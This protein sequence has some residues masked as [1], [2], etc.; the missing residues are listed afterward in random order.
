[1]KTVGVCLGASSVS[2][3]VLASSEPDREKKQST[4]FRSIYQQ[5][6]NHDGEPEGTLCAILQELPLH[7]YSGI[8]VT[9]RNLRHAAALSSVSE[10]EAVEY[11]Y[12]AFKPTDTT[13]PAILSAGGETTL[14]YLLTP[15]GQISN[16]IAGSKCAAGTGAFYLQQLRRMN[17]SVEQAA[18]AAASSNPYPISSRCSVFCKS[19]CTHAVNK[20]VPKGRV[21]AGLCEMIADKLLALLKAEDRHDVML[22]GGIARNRLVVEYLKA[23]VPGLIVPEAADCF[24]AYGAALWAA[25]NETIPFPGINGLFGTKARFS[26]TLPPLRDAEDKVV[27]KSMK[28]GE[29]RAGDTCILGLDVGSTT[30]KATLIREA[31]NA[32]L[33]SV[34]LRTSGNPVEAARRCYQQVADDIRQQVDPSTLDIRGVGICGSGRQLAGL[35]AMTDGV[36]NEIIAH[37]TAAIYFDDRVDTIFE[38]GGQDAK[39]TNIINGVPCDYA[40]NE[41]CSAGTGSFLEESAL[42]AL[43]VSMRE[44]AELA[45][46][47][48]QPAN[49]SDQC[50]AFIASDIKN[51]LHAGVSRNAILAG[52]VYSICMNYNNRVKGNRPVGRR[53]FMQGGVCYNRAVPLAMATLT[54]KEIV[55]PPEPGLMGAFGAALE[56]KERITK[57]ILKPGRYVLDAL[58]ER[59]AICQKTFICQGG[60]EKCDRKCEISL[61]SVE[62][63]QYPFGGACNRYYN[64]RTKQTYDVV[65]LNLVAKREQRVLGYVPKSPSARYCTGRIGI[66]RS[67]LTH[68]YFPLL[69]TFFREIGWEL[70]LPSGLSRKGM[71]KT[72]ASFCYPAELA[73]GY[74]DQLIEEAEHFD[75]VFLPQWK[76]LP[77]QNGSKHS[78]AC[79]IVQAEPYLMKMSFRSELTKKGIGKSKILS[80]LLDM[81]DGLQKAA[82]P[83]IEMARQM[84]VLTSRARS[85]FDK[86]VEAQDACLESLKT[87]GDEALDTLARHPDRI[88]VVVLARPYNGLASEANMGIPHKLAS[89]GIL[90]MPMD[91]LRTE[92]ADTKRHMYWAMG[93]LLLKA[94][95]IIKAHPQ[96]FAVYITNFSCGPDSFLIGYFRDIMGRKPSLTLELDSHVADAGLE[97]RIE[98]FLDIVKAYRKLARSS[99][100]LGC[101]PAAPQYQPAKIVAD[102]NSP[103]LRTSAGELL[104]LTDP[105]VTLLFP[106]MGRL[107]TEALAAAF[108]S[109]NIRTVVHPPASEDILKEGRA[110]TTCKECLPLILTT[111]TMLHYVRNRQ[112]PDEALIYFMPSASGPCR[113]GQYHVFME[114]LI[115]RLEIRDVA[116]LTLTTENAYGGRFWK[117]IQRRTWWSVVVSDAL[118][119]IHS[120]LMANAQNVS[121]ALDVFEREWHQIKRA[122]ASNDLKGLLEQ[123]A[124]SA[125]QLQQVA[126]KRP[127]EEVPL[128]YLTGEIFVRRDELSRQ[129]L[130]RKMAQRGFATTCSPNAEWIQYCHYLV[131]RGHLGKDRSLMGRM[132]NFGISSIMRRD[133][134]Q[135]L[136]VLSTSGFIHSEPTDVGKI[137]QIAEPYISGTKL[138]GEAALTVGG[139]LHHVGTRASG[140]IAIGPFGCMPHRISEAILQEVTSAP[141][142]HHVDNTA[143]LGQ[144]LE[145]QSMLPFLAIE[146]DGFPWPQLTEAKLD[147]FMQQACRLHHSMRAAATKTRG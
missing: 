73:H 76:S 136:A 105:R 11:A 91:C 144:V 79:P 24:E 141:D 43:G 122:L 48:E 96:L 69:A 5:S 14:A 19:D 32:L 135:I 70:C 116:L 71:Q 82:R 109:L 103:R 99:P 125:R 59:E 20:G 146:T 13:P 138:T 46:R 147:A 4:P 94:A 137:I 21:V 140:A 34:Y 22:I 111:G 92:S 55:V 50:A 107:A 132:I 68:S 98:A 25:E 117:Q 124:G 30:T 1:M 115:Q 37:A 3:V 47:A 35:H 110:H 104:S 29:V 145:D 6:R 127:V 18:D 131:N 62:G 114:D 12:Q 102:A 39:Y 139:T 44:I 63:T 65:N 93:Q 74:F 142:K 45:I 31:D 85:A 84:G 87:M 123:L 113:F 61:I 10:A 42:E 89:R 53:V 95:R 16:V 28:R 108:K 60:K 128:I 23:Q 51:A 36:L 75:Y 129:G 100:Q 52:L 26:A 9:G 8:A 7:T 143:T 90:V 80:P 27:F 17:L 56:V 67:F 66:N 126:L 54:G 57:G 97:T 78:Q 72:G 134:K 77:A 119:D 58:A 40:M 120:M 130:T 133:E 118:D 101:P 33:A 81:T 49:F 2:V 121:D 88:G 15:K 38:I 106:S 64:L 83:L 86:A 41:A 112:R